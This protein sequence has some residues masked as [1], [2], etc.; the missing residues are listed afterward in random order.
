[1]IYPQRRFAAHHSLRELGQLLVRGQPVFG[2]QLA[3]KWPDNAGSLE[4]KYQKCSMSHFVIFAITVQV[5]CLLL[6]T[7]YAKPPYLFPP[8]LL[9]AQH[10]L[11]KSDIGPLQ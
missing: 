2:G 8:L 4:L 6:D 7:N 9:A 10:P 1:M 5:R 11:R 3:H